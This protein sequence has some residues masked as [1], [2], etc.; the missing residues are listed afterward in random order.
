V[1]AE[2]SSSSP[3]EKLYLY[4]SIT[5]ANF[6]WTDLSINK[7]SSFIGPISQAWQK[8]FLEKLNLNI[9]DFQIC[10]LDC[11]LF[12]KEWESKS[13]SEAIKI[14][15]KYENARLIKVYIN[16]WD[17]STSDEKVFYWEGRVALFDIKNNNVITTIKVPYQKREFTLTEM[18][19]LNSKLG[20]LI[21]RSALGTFIQVKDLFRKNEIADNMARLKVVGHKRLSDAMDLAN[22]LQ[23]K[24][25]N[26][27]LKV[28][29]DGFSKEEANFKCFYQSEEKSF[30][31][32]LSQLKELKSSE[33]YN[34][35]NQ[36]KDSRFVLRLLTK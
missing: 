33:S 9:E 2:I 30:S 19:S 31:D 7:E 5:P 26:I 36:S 15:E 32:L 22:L 8:W 6:N 24:G 14:P 4:S 28:K 21:Y 12:L 10:E 20:S 35:V 17:K 34:L 3:K 27:G 13:D 23:A 11:Q 16:L 25:V 18:N 1:R 29:L